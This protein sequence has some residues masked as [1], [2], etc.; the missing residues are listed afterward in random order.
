MPKHCAAA[1]QL[2]EYKGNTE[3]AAYLNRQAET[4]ENAVKEVFRDDARHGFLCSLPQTSETLYEH[5]QALMLAL[6]PLSAEATALLLDQLTTGS[7]QPISLSAYPYLLRGFLKAGMRGEQMILPRLRKTFDPILFSGATSLWETTA[8]SDD[9]G[10]AG[11]L[12][13][14]WSGLFPYF[15]GRVLL[16]VW[17]LSPGFRTFEVNPVSCG[18]THAEGEIPTPSGKIRV[19]WQR[20]AAGKLDVTVQKPDNLQCIAGKNVASLQLV[21][22]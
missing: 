21:K 9:F 13:H 14:A 17:P 19:R 8:G 10:A 4:I 6:V 1:G 15:S 22:G 5:V 12:C 7:M 3:R 11:S 2:H 20:N 18:L 16:G